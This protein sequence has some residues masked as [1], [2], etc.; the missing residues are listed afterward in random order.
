MRGAERLKKELVCAREEEFLASNCN[1]VLRISKA[2]ASY[3]GSGLAQRHCLLC[4]EAFAASVDAVDRHLQ[5]HEASEV[6]RAYMYSGGKTAGCGKPILRPA[7]HSCWAKGAY[8]SG[9]FAKLR[10][11]KI[12]REAYS[13]RS[14]WKCSDR[15]LVIPLKW[16]CSGND[17]D[18]LAR[19]MREHLQRKKT[20]GSC[21]LAKGRA[22]LGKNKGTGK[23]KSKRRTPKVFGVRCI[24]GG[25][26]TIRNRWNQM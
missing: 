24:G 16:K 2:N 3:S 8:T 12:N 6:T 21:R 20:P 26:G 10:R 25:K 15:G 11:V 7:E 13:E 18:Q 5:A 19:K 22:R 23:E 9:S 14:N 17:I 1:R 4:G